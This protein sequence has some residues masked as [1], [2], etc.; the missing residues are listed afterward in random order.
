MTAMCRRS[1]L[2]TAIAL[3]FSGGCGSARVAHAATTAR[4]PAFF[5]FDRRFGDSVTAARKWRFGGATVID[6]GKVDL[7][8]AWHGKIGTA[9]GRGAHIEGLTPWSATYICEQLG[10]EHGLRWRAS[11]RAASELAAWALMPRS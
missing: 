7:W 11:P 3:G 6:A 4:L 8:H 2:E 5:I 9:L 1:V 10:R